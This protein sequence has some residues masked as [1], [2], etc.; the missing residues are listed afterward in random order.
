MARLNNLLATHNMNIRSQTLSTRGQLGYAV[1]DVTGIAPADL[2]VEL[3]ALD[4]TVRV[5]ML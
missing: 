5:R 1:T 2:L 4:E 3:E